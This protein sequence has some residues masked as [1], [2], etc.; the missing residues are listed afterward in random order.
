MFVAQVRLSSLD[1]CL[2]KDKFQRISSHLV[3]PALDVALHHNDISNK[4]CLDEGFDII[5]H[6][7]AVVAKDKML[8]RA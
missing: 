4:V 7:V 8:L 1:R 3:Q 5:A 6:V 2:R